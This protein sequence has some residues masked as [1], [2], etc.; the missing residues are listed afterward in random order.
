MVALEHDIAL[1]H[2]IRLLVVCHDERL[3]DGLERV[4]L[5][6]GDRRAGRRVRVCVPHQLDTP[7][8]ALTQ[9]S[10]HPQVHEL[11]VDFVALFVNRLQ[12]SCALLR[13]VRPNQETGEGVFGRVTMA[14]PVLIEFETGLLRLAPVS[15]QMLS[16][17]SDE[18]GHGLRLF[19][20]RC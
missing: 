12:L 9:R 2:H 7:K 11:H 20:F 10:D 1:V 16:L 13:C 15:I 5:V 14:N 8:S 17:V 19:P 3:R 18:R 4:N 6:L